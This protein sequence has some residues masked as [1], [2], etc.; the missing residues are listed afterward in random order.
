MV[1]ALFPSSVKERMSDTEN[2]SGNADLNPDLDLDALIAEL[3]AAF[4]STA[5]DVTGDEYPLPEKK[6]VKYTNGD[7]TV[8]CR[9]WEGRGA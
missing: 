5:F 2:V 8:L 3:A 6:T 7:G 4:P 9:G 1:L